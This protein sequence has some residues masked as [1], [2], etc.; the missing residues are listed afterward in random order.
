MVHSCALELFDFGRAFEF[1]MCTEESRKN[2]SSEYTSILLSGPACANI[3]KIDWKRLEECSE[4]PKGV[5]LHR[6]AGQSTK[7]VNVHRVP[8]VQIDGEHLSGSQ[9]TGSNLLRTVCDRY[10]GAKPEACPAK[11]ADDDGDD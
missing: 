7:F 2:W 4:G 1:I 5:E 3:T 10:E 6:T 8:Y 11:S 9:I